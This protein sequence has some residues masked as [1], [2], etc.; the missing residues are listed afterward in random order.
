[1]KKVIL[2]ITAFIL[3]SFSALV[4]VSAEAPVD[5]EAS[6]DENF[7]E[8]NQ[9]KLTVTVKNILESDTLSDIGISLV[10]PEGVTC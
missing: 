9:G 8:D 1:M 2:F 7:A 10:L 6:F 5:I 3:L 4:S